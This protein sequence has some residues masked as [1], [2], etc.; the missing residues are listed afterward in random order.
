MG[1]GG[2]ERGV[3]LEDITTMRG[4]GWMAE[5]RE[6]WNKR[7]KEGKTQPSVFHCPPA[8]CGPGGSVQVEV[9]VL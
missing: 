9:H 2:R 4:D 1:N 5:E 3:D 6:V 8:S 7:R